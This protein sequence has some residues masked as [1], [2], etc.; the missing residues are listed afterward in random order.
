MFAA[1]LVDE[2]RALLTRGL[3]ANRNAMQALGYRQV[4]EHLR[5]ERGLAETIALVKTK[6]W[7]FARRQGTWFRGQLRSEPVP[8][9]P[10]SEPAE[11]ASELATRITTRSAVA[12][13]D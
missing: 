10:K 8:L 3:D 1:G 9:A 13:L 2:T 12:P 7:Q 11:V 4:V 5:G 6:T